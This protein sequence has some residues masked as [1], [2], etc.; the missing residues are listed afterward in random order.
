MISRPEGSWI[1]PGGPVPMKAHPGSVTISEISTMLAQVA[2][3]SVLSMVNT[4]LL[5]RQKA[6]MIFPVD[7]SSTAAGFP[8]YCNQ[9]KIFGRLRALKREGPQGP[10]NKDMHVIKGAGNKDMHVINFPLENSWYYADQVVLRKA[11]LHHPNHK[12]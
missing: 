10:G 1:P 5:F 2:P 11:E 6:R 7:A 12:S 4:F 9:T 8:E 3:S